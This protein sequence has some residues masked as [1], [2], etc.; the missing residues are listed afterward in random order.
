MRDYFSPQTSKALG[1]YVYALVDPR[2]QCDASSGIFYIGKGIRQ[3]CFSHA[4]LEERAADFPRQEEG[5]DLK[6]NTIREI[7]AAGLKPRVAIVAHA[8]RDDNHALQIEAILIHAFGLT[9]KQ[10][11]H[12]TNKYWQSSNQLEERYGVPIQRTEIPGTVL[13]VGLNRSYLGTKGDAEKI[14]QVTLG[15]WGLA[16]HKGKQIDYIIGVHRGLMVS[17]YRVEKHNGEAVMWQTNTDDRQKGAR[18]RY[19]WSAVEDVDLAEAFKDRALVEG[20]NTLS[21]LQRNTATLFLPASS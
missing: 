16:P 5:A 7:L 9:N 11:G 18:R 14:K 2:V 13:L 1:H 20:G 17:F 21:I 3:R 10:S 12:H 4:A 15:D 6:R 8:L 19:R